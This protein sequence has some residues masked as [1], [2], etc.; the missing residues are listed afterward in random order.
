MGRARESGRGGWE[1]GGSRRRRGNGKE[2]R[3][4]EGEVGREGDGEEK[5]ALMGTGEQKAKDPSSPFH[6]LPLPSPSLS[7][8]SSSPHPPFTPPPPRPSPNTL[9]VP[10]LLPGEARR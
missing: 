2:K 3:E 6:S 1:G 7:H 4:G 9:P 10:H 8:F 5:G